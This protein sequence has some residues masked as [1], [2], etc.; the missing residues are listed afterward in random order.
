M[1]DASLLQI[2][3]TFNLSWKEYRKVRREV[4][5]RL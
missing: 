3:D 2:L 5:K 4:K 1:D